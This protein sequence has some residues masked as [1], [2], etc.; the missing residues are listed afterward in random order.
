MGF[1]CDPQEGET[2]LPPAS[3]GPVSKYNAEGKYEVHKDQP[4]ETAYRMVEWHWREW[5][6]PYDRVERS[7]L[8]DVPYQRYPRTFIPPPSVELSISTAADGQRIITAGSID[9]IDENQKTSGSE[10]HP[11]LWVLDSPVTRF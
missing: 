10:K 3:R 11:V 4:M 1:S 8:V 6:G 7:K 5:H 2:I 9:Y